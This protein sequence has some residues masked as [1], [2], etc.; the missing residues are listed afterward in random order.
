[1][2]KGHIF[3]SH[4]VIDMLIKKHSDDYLRFAASFSG[5]NLKTN[6]VHAQIALQIP[7][8]NVT[9]EPQGSAWSEQIHGEPGSCASWKRH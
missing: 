5:A 3:D 6:I 4:F 7:Q 8:C 9:V 1:V 2:P